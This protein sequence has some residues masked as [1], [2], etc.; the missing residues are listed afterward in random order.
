M[1]KKFLNFLFVLLLLGST[2]YSQTKTI[3]GIVTGKDDNAPIPGVS[4]T[5]SDAKT[6]TTTGANGTYTIKAP[7]GSHLLVFSSL[8]YVSQTVVITG[9]KVNVAL[10]TNQKALNEVLVVGYG[11][12]TKRENVGSVAQIKGADIAQQPV[13]NFEQALAGKASGVQITVPNGVLNTPPVFHIRG[14]NSISLSSQPLIVVD[15]VVSFSGDYS[16]GESGGN[17]LA[18]INPEDIESIDILKDASATAIYGSRGANGVVVITTKK[19]KKGTSTVTVD[20]WTGVTNVIRLPKVLDAFQYVALKNEALTN[21]GSYNT[22]VTSPQTIPLAYTEVAND[23]NGNPI[24]TDW[25]KVVYRKAYQYNTTVSLSGG[26]DKTTYYASG[27]YSNQQGVLRKNDFINKSMLFNIDHKANKYI[28]YGAKLSYA[29]QLNLAATSSGSLATEA[30]A[31]AGLGRLAVLLPPNL[32]VYLN[33]GSYNSSTSGI[34]ILNNKGYSISY[35]N[36]QVALDLDRAN[37]EINHTAAN[38]YLIANPL[39]WIT[40]KTQYG[41]DYLYTNNDSF[42]NPVNNATPSAAVNY[43]Q[44]RRWDWVNTAQFDK[45][46]GAHALSL[47][48][49]NE[50]QRTTLY[51]FGLTRTVLSDPAFNQIQSGFI[52]N[53]TN[54]LNTGE[55]YLVSFFGR[56]NYNFD[57]KY[58]IS[59]TIRRDG[60]SGFGKDQKYGNFPGVGIG[61]EIAKEKFWTDLKA[62][63]IFSSFKLRG[64]F[65]K[66]GNNNIG[67]FASLSF[68]STGVYNTNASLGP[69]TTGNTSLAWETSQKYDAGFDFGILNDRITGS[70]GWYKNDVTGLLFNVPPAP[71]AGLAGSPLVNIGSLYNKGYE[72]NIDALVINKGAFRWSANFNVSY[73]DNRITSLPGGLPITYS[74]SSL[75]ITNINR[76]GGGVGDLYIIKSAGIDPANGRRIFINGKGVPIEYSFSGTTHYYNMDGTPYLKADGI[77]PNTINQTADASDYGNS[78]PKWIG[79]F[80]NTFRYKN[81]DLST[82]LTFQTGFKLYYGTGATL[83]DQ[84]FWN[85]SADILDHW[86]TP[87]QMARYPKVVFGDNVSNGT[88]FPTDFNTY[89]GNFLKV[90]T[91]N[92]GYTLPRTLMSKAGISNVRFYVSGYNLFIFTHYPGSDPEVGSNGTSNS[93]QGV[94]RNTAANGRTFTAGVSIKF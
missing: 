3:T 64:S 60:Y 36:P 33:D 61:W 15:G 58:F 86:T 82:T 91:L 45:T 56:L 26:N 46:F 63:Q 39:S 94:D 72:L 8:G 2:A 89:S 50:Q 22:T 6:G 23:A 67:D 52:N 16:G 13:Q 49:G 59:G 53:S 14:T 70:L 30:Y 43:A 83:T 28:S 87:G 78:V 47:L 38:F 54:N 90:K 37:N 27:N 12:Q 5:V 19:G 79:G 81:F 9:S 76:V 31:T 11:T 57:H 65:G 42:S 29:D 40:L 17:A 93:S 1:K 35:P 20:G 55:N 80:S 48:V 51:Q 41:V 73:N 62:D 88:S 18:N 10:E 69:N 84:R 4:V 34:G 7:A 32:P 85:N 44:N 74:T 68:Y 92:I 24:N 21:A 25:T 71:S 66:T 75:E 77:T